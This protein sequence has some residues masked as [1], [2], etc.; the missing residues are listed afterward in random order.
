MSVIPEL[1]R[2]RQRDHE[3]KAR[4]DFTVRLWRIH[5]KFISTVLGACGEERCRPGGQVTSWKPLQ[6]S[7]GKKL[8]TLGHACICSSGRRGLGKYT[9]EY[10]I[11]RG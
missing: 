11:V 8:W 10:S 6:Y 7:S 1:R 2:L 4:L 9:C 3:F 5:V